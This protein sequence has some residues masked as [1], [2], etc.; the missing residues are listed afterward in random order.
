[1]HPLCNF[2]AHVA[3]GVV[4]RRHCLCRGVVAAAQHTDRDFCH[5]KVGRDLYPGDG[6]QPDETRVFHFTDNVNDLPLHVL[7][8][9]AHMIGLR[10][11]SLL[12]P[13]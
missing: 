10:H 13:Q 5:I 11:I 12:I 4:Q 2:T 3:R 1:M 7:C 8:E 6:D 9:T